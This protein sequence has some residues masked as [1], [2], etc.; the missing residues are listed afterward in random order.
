MKRTCV[1]VGAGHRAMAYASHAR[2]HPDRMEV[3][4]VAD[5]VELRRQQ[6]AGMFDLDPANIFSSAEDLAARPKMADFVINGTMDHEHVP[7][8]LP[9]LRRGYDILLEKPF[10]T[11]PTEMWD[12][13]ETAGETGCK[14][15]IC[16]VLRHAP[17]YAAIRREVVDGAI[18][19]IININ[20]VEHVS[21]HHMAVGYVRGKWRRSDQCKSPMLMSKSCH[22]LDLITWMKSGIAPRRVSSFG[23]N[24]QFRPENAPRDSGTRCLVDCPIEG[25]CLYSARKHYLD[26]PKRWAAYAWSSLEHLESPSIEKM[27]ESLKTSPYGQCVWKTDM[28]VVDHQ[29]VVIEFEDGATAT[30]N[31]V[32]GSAKPLRALHLIGT[33]G[34]IQGCLEDDRYVVRHI[35]PRPGHE[36][37]ERTVDLNETGDKTGAHG[38]HAGGDSRLVGDFLDYLDG[39]EPSISTTSLEDS[40]AGHLIGFCAHQSMAENKVVE[41]TM[42]R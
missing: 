23:S 20:A 29:S 35:D 32:G 17:F 40:V 13:V 19:D 8:S 27:T 14:V 1:I 4:G 33:H 39:N 25:E 12:L 9:L 22:D 37:S 7:T 34:E 3:I 16:H 28:N 5:P 18:G 24:M 38:G 10:A 30:L 11:N 36:F 21:Y 42:R 15:A 41:I 6:A 2:E 26:H 31:M